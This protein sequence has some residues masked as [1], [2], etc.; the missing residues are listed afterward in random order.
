M[1]LAIDTST[2]NAG[3]LLWD[4]DRPV[5][6][7]TWRS[8]Y[9]HTA[10][11]M[12]AVRQALQ[13][14][15]TTPRELEGIA[16]A[17]GPGGFS[18]L[19]VGISAAKG[20]ALPWGTP[21]VGISTLETEAYPYAETGFPVCPLLNIGRRDMAWTIYRKDADGWRKVKDETITANADLAT[22]L[23]TDALI[24]G[25]GTLTAAPLLQ[26]SNP[27]SHQAPPHS[28]PSVIPAP[29]SRHSRESGNPL[30]NPPFPHIIEYPGPS[31]RLWALAR[32]AS[33]RLE[34]GES[35][36]ANSL[37]PL[38]L[39]KPSITPPNPPKRVRR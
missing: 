20:L 6:S 5:Y 30:P 33:D 4:D 2:P 13:Q 27:Q 10:H 1:L 39:R 24:C 32:L 15:G 9:N 19:R 18:A 22:T 25:E 38:Y 36:D 28:S 8:A 26:A 21:L 3:V 16:V 12:P 37:Q 31:L 23:P 34:R 11:L 29:L 14:A 7:H 17:L 35:D